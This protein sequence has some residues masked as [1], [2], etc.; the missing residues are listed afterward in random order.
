MEA[1]IELHAARLRDRWLQA[2]DELHTEA[3]R[4][5]TADVDAAEVIAL[6]HVLE[7]RAHDA[8]AHY[9]DAVLGR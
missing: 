9:R 8:F 4:I 5:R 7:E 6:L 2:V 3:Q 1:S